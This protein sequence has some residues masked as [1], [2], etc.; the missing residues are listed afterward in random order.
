MIHDQSV[1][2]VISKIRNQPQ[3]RTMVYPY[4]FNFDSDKTWNFGSSGGF[5]KCFDCNVMIM[6]FD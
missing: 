2:G 3:D 1:D 6:T 5:I 4:K